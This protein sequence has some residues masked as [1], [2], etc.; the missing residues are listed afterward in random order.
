VAGGGLGPALNSLENVF[1]FCF[2]FF[3]TVPSS[4]EPDFL[5]NLVHLGP[6]ARGI[7]GGVSWSPWGELGCDGWAALQLGFL[8]APLSS[9]KEGLWG[10]TCCT[11]PIPVPQG[12]PAPS[13]VQGRP[14]KFT[15]AKPDAPACYGL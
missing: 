14:T 13:S 4:P 5:K 2:V 7:S 8:I 3:L 12:L 15:V 6:G 11:S 10:A 1:A 9:P